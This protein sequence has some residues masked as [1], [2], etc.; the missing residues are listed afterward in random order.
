MPEAQFVV[1]F[2]R[3]TNNCSMNFDAKFLKLLVLIDPFIIN[4]EM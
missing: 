3:L 1:C 4:M 2:Q